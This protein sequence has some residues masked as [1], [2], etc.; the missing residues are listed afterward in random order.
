MKS[1]DT[2]AKIIMLSASINMKKNKEGNGSLDLRTQD[3]IKICHNYSFKFC[4]ICICHKKIIIKKN[5][6][7]GPIKKIVGLEFHLV[8]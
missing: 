3:L 2:L 6:G 7:P 5:S 1:P 8:Y 4:A